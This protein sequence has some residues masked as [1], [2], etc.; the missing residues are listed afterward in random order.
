M[1]TSAAFSRTD[2][3]HRRP[4]ER[5]HLM[6]FRGPQKMQSRHPGGPGYRWS[7]PSFSPVSEEM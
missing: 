1:G 5:G 4:G 3:D 2:H 7:S 6:I